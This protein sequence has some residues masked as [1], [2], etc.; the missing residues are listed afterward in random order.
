[1]GVAT[2]SR[3][4]SKG[5]NVAVLSR[6]AQRLQ[7]D[8]ASIQ[9]SNANVKVQ[10]YPVDV[11]DHVALPKV[12]AKVQADL[13]EP[14]VVYFNAARVAPTTI[15]ETTSEEILEDFKVRCVPDQRI[16]RHFSTR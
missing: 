4:A 10:A 8:V 6:D 3:F 14:E 9:K 12:L 7:Q 1:M 2:G 11:G 16:R 5:F 15:G 13:G